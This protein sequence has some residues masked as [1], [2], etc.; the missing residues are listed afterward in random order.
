MHCGVLEKKKDTSR[1]TGEIWVKPVAQF[2]VL[3]QSVSRWSPHHGYVNVTLGKAEWRVFGN[4]L[5]LQLFHKSK[6]I[7][8]FKV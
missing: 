8:K 3:Y 2:I 7:S 5:Y 4:T 1:K 6:I